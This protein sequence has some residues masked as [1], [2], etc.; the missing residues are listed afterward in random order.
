MFRHEN[1]RISGSNNKYVLIHRVVSEAIYQPLPHPTGC[2]RL[3][4]ACIAHDC[5]MVLVA[6]RSHQTS[7][8]SD[9]HHTNGYFS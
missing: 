3:G 1:A 6:E 2:E 5:T 7:S 4:M 9:D 8:V